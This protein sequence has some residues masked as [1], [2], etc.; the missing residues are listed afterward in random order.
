MRVPPRGLR[1]RPHSAPRGRL[2]QYIE[3]LL[4]QCF[5]GSQHHAAIGGRGEWCA[6]PVADSAAGAGHDRDDRHEIVRFEFRLDDEITVTAGE[7]AIEITVAAEAAQRGARAERLKSRPLRRVERLR[8]GGTEYRLPERAT[9][10][11]SR[12]LAVEKRATP[13]G[14]DPAL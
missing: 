11:G 10:A 5:G 9:V 4:P 6:L 1:Y 7:H 12:R 8:G 2:S 13:L 14:A 3:R